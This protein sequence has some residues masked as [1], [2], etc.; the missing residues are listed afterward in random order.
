MAAVEA[1]EKIG[2]RQ[3]REFE[4]AQATWP[5]GERPGALRESASEFRRRFKAEGE[6]RAIRTVDLVSAGY[7]VTFAF[8]GA[9]RHVNP[10]VNVKEGLRRQVSLK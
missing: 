2:F 7:P 6:V 8:H 10:Y 4:A 5:R 9:A 1:P 3:I